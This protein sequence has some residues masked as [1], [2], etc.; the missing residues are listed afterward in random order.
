MRTSQSCL[1]L[2]RHSCLLFQIAK[3]KSDLERSALPPE[4]E[5]GSPEEEEAEAYGGPL[6]RTISYER[7]SPVT[8]YHLGMLLMSVAS[9]EEEAEKASRTSQSCLRLL[10]RACLSF[11]IFKRP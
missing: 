11:H 4:E 3:K 5:E 9:E 2:L 7:G 10:R 6:R 1:R 8:F